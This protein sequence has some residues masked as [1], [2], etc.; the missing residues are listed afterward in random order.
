[1]KP[2]VRVL[3][4]TAGLTTAVNVIHALRK[5]EDLDVYVVAVGLDDLTAGAQLADVFYPVPAVDVPGYMDAI[6]DVCTREEVDFVFPL[7]SREI[8]YFSKDVD[9]FLASR[10]IYFFV[11]AHSVVETCI[12]RV[13][14]SRFFES[15]GIPTPIRYS[16]WDNRLRFP[17]FLKPNKEGLPKHNCKVN[18][19]EEMFF[20]LRRYPESIVQEFIEGLEHTV[21]CLVCKGKVLACVPRAR[22]VVKDGKSVLGRTVEH[23]RLIDQVKDLLLRIGM[24]G[25]CNVQ[26]IEAVEGTLF[27]T[28]INP[29]LAA[30]GLP[31]TVEAG[32][33]IPEMMVKLF[34][35]MAVDPIEGYKRDLYMIRYLENI[36]VDS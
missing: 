18:D 17:L 19:R 35:G 8:A 10:S 36:Y 22:L 25:P 1:M 6:L 29:R 34:L 12:D 7:Y 14:L 28:E 16:R 21:D 27:F 33:N 4:T 24:N 32:V 20:Y 3:V 11:P 23:P 2:L 5:S 9:R 13:K 15:N 30:G 31:L 26:C